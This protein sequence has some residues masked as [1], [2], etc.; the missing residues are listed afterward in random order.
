M[1]RCVLF[2]VTVDGDGPQER[3]LESQERLARV[4]RQLVMADI[5]RAADCKVSG[6]TTKT[7]ALKNLQDL[8]QLIIRRSNDF[9]A[10]KKKILYIRTQE[11]C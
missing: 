6:C 8:N 7:R 10:T 4:G 11:S 9:V 2:E 3:D 5:C 1:T